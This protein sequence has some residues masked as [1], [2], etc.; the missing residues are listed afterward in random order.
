MHTE[1][2]NSNNNG[3]YNFSFG[4]GRYGEYGVLHTVPYRPAKIPNRDN[5]S[6]D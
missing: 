5:T 4:A 6:D 2:E 3:F 1:S